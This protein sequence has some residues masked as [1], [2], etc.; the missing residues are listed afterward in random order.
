MA[1]RQYAGI[2]NPVIQLA[3]P[4]ILSSYTASV[5]L[6]VGRAQR[7][8]FYTQI[9]L[10]AG[11]TITTVTCKLQRRYNDYDETAP[12]VLPYTDLASI[13]DTA[14]TQTLEVEHAFAA[15]A[16]PIAAPGAVRDW[17]LDPA[18]GLLDLTVNVKAN[19][20]GIAGDSVAVYMEL[21]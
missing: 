17:F 10:N 4:A 18:Y 8:R 12:V 6:Q 14:A 16:A 20:A 2:D 5:A 3:G 21:C 19:V 13:N 9:I 15:L 7:V 1:R 11:S